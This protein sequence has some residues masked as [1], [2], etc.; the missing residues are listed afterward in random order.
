MGIPLLEVPPG[1]S[2]EKLAEMYDA[3]ATHVDAGLNFYR[4]EIFRRE[5][6]RQT[7][8][9]LRYTLL[10]TIMTVVMTVATIINVCIA[11]K[12]IK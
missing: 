5:Q 7:K 3:E 11:F 8:A 2:D 1:L 9:M 12:M 6:E 10:I 4:Q